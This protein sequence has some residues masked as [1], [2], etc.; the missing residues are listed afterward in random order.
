M[1]PVGGSRCPQQSVGRGRSGHLG[2][3]TTLA[4]TGQKE[5][6]GIFR[7]AQCTVFLGKRMLGPILDPGHLS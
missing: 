1:E 5:G 6:P 3:H 7:V 2:S 4:W